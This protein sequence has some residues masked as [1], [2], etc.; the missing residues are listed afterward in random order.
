MGRFTPLL[1]AL[2]L[3]GCSSGPP[4]NITWT[5]LEK[6]ELL[7]GKT[8]ILEG[9]PGVS[10]PATNHHKGGMGFSLMDTAAG[11]SSSAHQ[12]VSVVLKAGEG[13]NQATVLPEGYTE[14]D[15][16]VHCG[17][18]GTA[19]FKDKIRVEGTLEFVYGPSIRVHKIEKLP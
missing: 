15:L 9:Y 8:V 19:I 11:L 10:V 17:V 18:G 3:A 1:V 7:K 12:Q 14:K 6:P 2:W 16:K 4:R 5:D 13:P